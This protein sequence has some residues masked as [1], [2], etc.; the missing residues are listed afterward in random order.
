[1]VSKKAQRYISTKIKKLR[2]EGYP[3]KQSEAIAYAMA[4]DK[5]Y[6][7]PKKR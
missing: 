3:Q 4:R 6:N 1:M 7:V 2:H 5:G